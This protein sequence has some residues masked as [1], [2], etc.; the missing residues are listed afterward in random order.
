MYA[1][2]S[3]YGGGR[4]G[5]GLE[6]P[7]ADRRHAPAAGKHRPYHAYRGH[8]WGDGMTAFRTPIEPENIKLL[9][10]ERIHDPQLR[11]NIARATRTS[12]VKRA[13]V[14]DDYPDWENMRDATHDIKRHVMRNNFV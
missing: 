14:V 11:G 5:R 2:R 12:L 10:A 7:D 8:P 1:I 4:H 3:Y 13:A 9:I 6:L